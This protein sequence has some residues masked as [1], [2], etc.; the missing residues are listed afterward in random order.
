[1]CVRIR[2]DAQG[3]NTRLETRHFAAI[4]SDKLEQAI[5]RQDTQYR[6]DLQVFIII[7]KRNSARVSANQQ[8]AGL[9]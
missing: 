7:Q 4:H 8:L 1:M 2:A 6:L 9:T 5:L 3:S